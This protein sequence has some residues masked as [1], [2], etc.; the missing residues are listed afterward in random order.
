MQ[1]A[2]TSR[3]L[4]YISAVDWRNVNNVAAGSEKGIETEDINVII[5]GGHFRA[6]GRTVTFQ[7]REKKIRSVVSH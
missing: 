4:S 1:S 5:P 6:C 7:N 2:A 3:T